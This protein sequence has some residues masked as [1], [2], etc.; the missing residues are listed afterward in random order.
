MNY[1]LILAAVGAT[2]ISNPRTTLSGEEAIDLGI[3]LVAHNFEYEV[4][5][6]PSPLFVRLELS[7]FNAC[8]VRDVGIDVLNAAGTLVYGSLI[9]KSNGQVYA[10][11]LERE[12]LDYTKMAIRCESGSNSLDYVYMFE[13]KDLIQ[14]P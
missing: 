9:T 2:Y 1:L 7:G 5:D 8:Q 3:E 14:T 13:I 4:M 12:Y 10:F 6:Q 11:R